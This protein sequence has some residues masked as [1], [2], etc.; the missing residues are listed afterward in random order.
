[1]KRNRFARLP[2]ILA[3]FLCV[4]AAFA[5]VKLPKVLSDHA[6]LQREAPI[7]IWG[8]A[9]P[10]EP[11][12]VSFVKQKLE[13][14]ADDLGKWSIYLS[15]EHA[16]GPYQLTVQGSNTLTLSDLLIGDVWFA[17]G[18][19]NMEMPLQGFPNSAALKD[20]AQEIA[21]S[22]QPQIR[23]L[24]VR[25]RA[26]DHPL[27]DQDDS[28][29]ACTP[30]TAADFSAVAYFFGR[31]IQQRE[32][33]PVGL[34]DDTWGGTPVEAWVSLDGI[35]S[36]SSLMP[37]FQEWSKMSNETADLAAIVAKEKRAD[38]AAQQ[39]G[40]PLPK[41]PWHP[42]P[43]SWA[44]A[45]LY[46]GMVAPFVDYSIKGAIW[47]QGESNSKRPLAPLYASVF[48][49]LIADWRS[50]WHEGNFP[51]LYV[52]ISSFTSNDTEI[53]GIIRDA[54]RRTLSVANTGMAVSLDVGQADNV[55]PPDKQTVGH[56]LAL[57]ARHL[58]YGEKVDDS[59]PLFRQA[60]PENSAIR[61]S[62]DHAEALAAKGGALRGFELAGEDHRF[63]AG[64]ATIDGATVIVNG[65][66][67]A[68]KYVRYGWANFSEANLYNGAD[69]PAAAFSSENTV[70]AGTVR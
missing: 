64:V 5:E 54:Q 11:V 39:A 3:T 15:P 6:V 63:V 53:W 70:D 34:I 62:F 10:G 21:S 20:G 68:P 56:R 28:W 66:V 52:Q 41:H 8:W 2:V 67:K 27:Y 61:V 14:H 4:S 42:N 47:Y 13:T 23:L 18:Q 46:N 22:N 33:V 38:A 17:S 55:H 48:P 26:S 43:E 60:M 51:F 37:V 1:M 45:F 19:S 36:D 12:T 7:H 29:T 16:G 49:A 25:T 69:L 59:G 31:E 50:K 65:P 57:T 30:E 58:A 9:E 32:K 24:R 35:S 44:P 40:A